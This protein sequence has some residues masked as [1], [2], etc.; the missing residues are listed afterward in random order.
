MH[1]D[2]PPLGSTVGPWR[3]LDRLDSG[4][5]GVVFRAQRA[6]LPASPPV[7]LKVARFPEDPRFQREMEALQRCLHPSI[8]RYEGSGLWTNSTGEHHP[9]LVMEVVAGTTLYEWF[10]QHPRC[11]LDVLQVLAQLAGALATA[12]GQGVIHRDV[13]G[14]NIRV[15]PEGRAVL[16]DWGSCWLSRARPLT[17]TPMPPGT[18]AYRPP[19]QRGF[20]HAHRKS[21]DARWVSRPPDDLYS[22]GVTLYRLVTGTYLP[23]CTDGISLVK[24]EVLKPSVLASVSPALEA[25]IL[26]LVS[27]DIGARGTAEQLMDEAT[28][29]AQ[30]GGREAQ[31]PILPL[32]TEAPSMKGRTSSDTPSREE[33]LS[34][35]DPAPMRREFWR[36]RFSPA[37]ARL[38]AMGC[39]AVAFVLF[40]VWPAPEKPCPPWIATTEKAPQFAPDAGVA[41]EMSSVQDVPQ[42]ALPTLLSL[43][44]P[45][46][47]TPMRGQRKPPC[48]RGET[49]INGACW[50]EVAREIPPCGDTM[51]D[52]DGR[53]FKAS[54]DAPRQPTSDQP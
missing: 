52:Y 10:R 27:D 50:V 18:S 42:T 53:C 30:A 25:L 26:R 15:T 49:A 32:L 4:S 9:Y 40:V 16:L 34:D 45:M 37:S 33:A 3:I 35:T 24:R 20:V 41:E 29:L 31:Q 8:P 43:G 11:S 47:K 28:R 7:A 1:E 12:H 48:E 39:A 5:Y 19:E 13:K 54:T 36:P 23:P 22:L 2:L 21:F 46:P 51:F 38:L 6:A 14:D 44:R 17:D